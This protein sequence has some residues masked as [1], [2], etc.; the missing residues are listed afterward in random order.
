[1]LNYVWSGM[2]LIGFV[3]SFFTG[4]MELIRNSPLDFLLFAGYCAVIGLFEECVFRGIIFSVLA[5]V[6]PKNKKGLLLTI[7]VSSIVFGLAHFLNGFSLGTLLQA[8]YSMLTGALFAFCLI[9]TKNIFCCAAVHS[10]YNFCGMLFDKKMLGGG[11]VFDLGT[12]ITMVI[13]SVIIGVFCIIRFV[14]YKEKER[15]ILYNKLGINE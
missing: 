15:I 6:F 7:L 10:V 11:V 9:K 2:I 13:V 12:I 4:K 5:G 3:V 8:G 14:F 1:M